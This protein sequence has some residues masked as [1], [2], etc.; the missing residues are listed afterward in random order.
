MKQ[1]IQYLRQAEEIDAKERILKTI[2]FFKENKD[3]ELQEILDLKEYWDS[4]YNSKKVNFILSR[5]DLKE[6]EKILNTFVYA[7]NE[8][9]REQEKQEEI[10]Q[11]RLKYST[12]L[13]INNKE[14]DGLK[15]KG[16]FNIEKLGAMGSYSQ[17]TEIEGKLSY[18][19]QHS[20]L[21]IIP[22]GKRTRGYIINN[23][24]IENE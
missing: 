21:M 6:F 11:I 24:F 20:R 22:K 10:D 7:N 13:D 14:L 9:K 16:F 8:F 3:K 12:E 4:D 2:E 19:P 17:F 15:V 1:T 5:L 18:L 23:G